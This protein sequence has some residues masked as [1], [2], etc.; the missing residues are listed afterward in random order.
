MSSPCRCAGA[1]TA[2]SITAAMKPH[3]GGRPVSIRRYLPA[4]CGWR[5]IRYRELQINAGNE[6]ATSATVVGTDPSNA[7]R[8][9]HVSRRG[10]NYKTKPIIAAGPK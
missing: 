2:R 6:A 1:I 5:H 3:G 8:G 10:P 4:R 9:R 7:K